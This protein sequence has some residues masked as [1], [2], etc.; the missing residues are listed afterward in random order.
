M[1]WLALLGSK[2]GLKQHCS[3]IAVEGEYFDRAMF[4]PGQV[5]R[6]W[7]PCKIRVVPTFPPIDVNEICHP[8]SSIPPL[9]CKS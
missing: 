2:G 3:G 7:F 4:W 1:Q 8:V 6:T 9:R 5:L